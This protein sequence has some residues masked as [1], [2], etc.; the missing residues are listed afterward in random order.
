[1]AP[2]EGFPFPKPI[3]VTL[4]QSSQHRQV[5]S[6]KPKPHLLPSL[7]LWVIALHVSLAY[8]LYALWEARTK[9][10]TVGARP[11]PAT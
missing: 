7:Y 11:K 6:R 5:N 4:Y 8:S 1:M 9:G 3:I 2:D 10:T